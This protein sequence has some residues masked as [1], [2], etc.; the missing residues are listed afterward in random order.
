MFQKAAEK[1][2]EFRK[3]LLEVHNTNVRDFNVLPQTGEVEVTEEWEIVISENADRVILAA[4]KDLQDYFFTS[5][6]MSLRLVRSAN[7][8]EE[9]EN[10]VNKIVY[11]TKETATELGEALDTP[12]SYRFI[13]TEDRIVLCGYD[14]RG[15]GQ[16]SYYL[17]DLM[18]FKHAPIVETG[19]VSRKPHFSPR[20]VH[21]GYGLDMFPDAHLSK[22]AHAGMDAILVFTKDVDITPQGYLDFNELIYRAAAYGID[23]YAFSFLFSERSSKVLSRSS[24]PSW[25]YSLIFSSLS[26]STGVLN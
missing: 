10:G 1:N 6:D 21:S 7:I 8:L 12:R 24:V 26:I 25:K 2:Y 22:I 3:R 20:M 18:N 5:M 16:A 14:D 15:A 23:V 4:A 17:E 11:I 13:A 9:A 19:E